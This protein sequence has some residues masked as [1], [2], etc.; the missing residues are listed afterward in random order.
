MP[1]SSLT[2]L[3]PLHPWLPSRLHTSCPIMEPM[4]VVLISTY[5]LGRQPFGLAS[6][7]AWLRRAGAEVACFDVSRQPLDED[8]VHAADLVAFYVPMHTATRL[9]VQLLET[10]RQLNPRAH[11]CFYGLYAPVNEPYLR[12]LGV[13]TILGGEF[14]EGLVALSERLSSSL[15]TQNACHSEPAAAGEESA[16]GFPLSAGNADPSAH[17]TGLGITQPVA[18]PALPEQGGGQ[19]PHS[20][21]MQAEPVVSLA[22]L[23]FLT[24]DRAGLPRPSHYA[25][26]V[27]PDGAHRTAG[28]TEASRGCKHLCRHCPIVPVYH[29]AFRVVQPDVV[30]ADIRQQ[31]EAGAQHITFGDPDFFNGPAHAVGIVRKLHDEFPQLTYDVTIKVEHLLKHANYLR[32]LRETGCLFITSAVESLDDAV[33]RRLDKGHTR[34]DFLRVVK[35]LREEHL[36]LQPT[37]VP[38]TPWTTPEGY[39]DLLR[40]LA[41]LGLVEAVPPIQLAIR[42]LIPAGSRLLELKEVRDLV[43]PFDPAALAYPWKHPDPRVDALCDE[44]QE[45]VRASEKLKRP[46]AKTFERIWDAAARADAQAPHSDERRAGHGPAP[47]ADA[48]TR[49]AAMPVLVARAAIPYLN[50]PWYC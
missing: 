41:E 40:V 32:A 34:A 35:R 47:A 6:P 43:G 16:F 46:R 49:L 38:F 24:P 28:Y 12:G 15:T 21:G 10:V 30:L 22:R 18:G 2:S 7:A 33:L 42:L 39:L 48:E 8:A 1:A 31:V 27:M 13:G 37:F 44:V 25:H 5:E 14:E 17:K 3:V 11:I 26:V 23:Q 19:P 29:G 50:E 4:R 20:E 9:A 45:I 36:A